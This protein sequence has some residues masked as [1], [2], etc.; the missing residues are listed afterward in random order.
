[1]GVTIRSSVPEQ[2]LRRCLAY[3]AGWAVWQLPPA[4]RWY[5]TSVIT[6]AAAAAGS[7]AVL[8]PWRASDALLFA[9]LVSFGGLAMEMT[10]VA[11]PLP[12][13]DKDV[14]GIWF[15]PVG[16]LLPPV[17]CLLAP[18]ATF[19][20]LQL[21]TRRTIAHRRVFSA[22]ASGLA[23]CAASLASGVLRSRWPRL[24][25]GTGAQ[26]LLWLL[27]AASCALLWSAVNQA[28]VMTAVKLSDP[29]AS[30]RERL[31][32]REPLLTDA[33]EICVGLLLAA[34][35]A[36]ISAALLLPALPLV[37]MLQ[38]SLRY[39]QL[40]SAARLDAKTGLLNAGAWRAEATVQLARAQRTGS[41]V[42]LAMCDLDHFK[43]INDQHGHLAGDTV[44][45]A[46]AATLRAGLRPYD[47]IGRFG[48]EEFTILLCG[49]SPAEAF[50]VADRLRASLAAQHISTGQGH[51][52]LR[53]TVSIG[54][55]A[56]SDP[57]SRDLTDLLT[58]ADAA[59]YAAKAG[60][61]NTV[62]L[63]DD[64]A[65]PARLHSELP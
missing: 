30:V 34:A 44:L 60:G 53:V 49:S 6:L 61:R 19:G 1:M 13:L 29:T 8:T 33:C 16:L 62:R 7:A 32:S 31:L 11:Q 25:P 64:E 41:P 65:D 3:P 15:I 21:R 35:I 14:H 22:A 63:A 37:I 59:L 38:R 56:T 10:R 54:I 24:W 43:T 5:V 28:L 50:A 18:V 58:S 9:M 46:A 52:P 4:L 40:Q 45:A 20:L 42:A 26:T 2:A 47:L 51:E 39:T 12:G 17:Y 36:A 48:G 55:A 27:V 57:A 23:L